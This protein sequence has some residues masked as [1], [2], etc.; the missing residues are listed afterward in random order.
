MSRKRFSRARGP[1]PRMQWYGGQKLITVETTASTSV[2]EVIQLRP[3]HT[4]LDAVR[5]L[6]HVRTI[7]NASISRVTIGVPYL[8]NLAV[9]IQDTDASGNLTDVLDIQATDPFVTSNTELMHYT[10]LPIPATT[11]NGGNPGVQVVTNEVLCRHYDI[12]VKRRMNLS[13]QA[14]TLTTAADVS[15]VIRVVYTWRSLFQ[16]S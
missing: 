11:T 5:N 4:S 13:R 9:A 10:C 16:T 14:L 1:R 15:G 8:L 12:K 2:S 3:P 7:L 6:T